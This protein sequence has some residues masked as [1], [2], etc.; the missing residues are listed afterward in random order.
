M[1]AI[2][3][4]SFRNPDSNRPY[5]KKFLQRRKLIIMIVV[6]SLM[7]S[8]EEFI[9]VDL[10]ANQL[11]GETV[12]EDIN[13]AEAALVN[14]YSRLRDQVLVTGQANGMGNLMGFYADELDLYNPSRYD[15]LSFYNNN[16]LP[17]NNSV[18]RLWFDSYNL[19]YAANAVIEGVG[20]SALTKEQKGQLI[21]EALF[22]RSFLHFYLLNLFGEIPFISVTD[23]RINAD[24]G[25][26]PIPVFYEKI[27]A[28]LLE[29]KELLPEK[30]LSPGRVRPNGYAASALLARVY[31]Y[32]EDWENAAEESTRIINSPLYE[33]E[34][35]L[36]Q[37]FLKNSTGTIWQ[38]QPGVKGANTFEAKI[39]VF[40]VGPPPVSA[41]TDVLV[42][43]FEQGDK[44][45]SNWVRAV[46]DSTEIWYHVNKYKL[47]S[48]TPTSEEFS[49]IFRLAEQ[50]LIRA[51]A[52]AQQG[53]ILAALEDLN[54]VRNRA[55]LEELLLDSKVEILD[56]VYDE[57]R[58]ELFLE[59]GHRWFDLKRTGRAD[60]ILSLLKPG[61]DETDILLPIPEKELTLNPNLQPQNP[62]Y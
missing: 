57:R 6:T 26:M 21:G 60:G 8:C 38:F 23:Y 27:V 62:G 53:N 56:A 14:I 30:N 46:G 54:K 58:H 3:K 19:I 22:I 20:K 32:M 61:W 15:L 7:V 55:G 33:L 44:R 39:F 31:L 35:D 36:S 9:E 12:F 42:E 52:R 24:A 29:A 10:P 49:I 59:Y 43:S 51:E 25:R 18:E 47:N 4:N 5:Y 37:V 16:V 28:D 40:D 1:R 41:M 11:M 17:S 48:N 34:E 45:F 50:Y 2:F 13:T